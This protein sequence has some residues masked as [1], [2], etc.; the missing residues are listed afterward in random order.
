[1]QRSIYLNNASDEDITA[2]LE[3][4]VLKIVVPKTSPP[5]KSKKISIE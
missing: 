2:K 4:G 5:D 3:E 1:M